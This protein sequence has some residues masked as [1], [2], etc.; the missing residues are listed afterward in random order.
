M[1][2]GVDH[3]RDRDLIDRLHRLVERNW[4]KP[5]SRSIRG[6]DDA[7]AGSETMRGAATSSTESGPSPA[8]GPRSRMSPRIRCSPP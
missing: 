7:I 4:E 5:K 2:S 8:G 3:R 1:Q 6:A